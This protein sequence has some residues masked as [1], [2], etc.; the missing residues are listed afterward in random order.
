MTT[1]IIAALRILGRFDMIPFAKVLTSFIAPSASFGIA[2][3]TP[4]SNE[5]TISDAESI[6]TSRLS[7]IALAI[8]STIVKAIFII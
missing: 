2:L 4:S 6:K 1:N 7:I 5:K 8:D 3:R